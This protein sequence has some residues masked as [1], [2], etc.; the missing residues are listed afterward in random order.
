MLARIDD[1][2]LNKAQKTCDKFQRL[3]GLTKFRLEKWATIIAV[4]SYW[5]FAIEVRVLFLTLYSCIL[6]AMYFF[7]VRD[8]EAQEKAFLARN[9]LRDNI[10]Y[11]GGRIVSLVLY[12]ITLPLTLSLALASSAPELLWFCGWMASVLSKTYFSACIPRPPSKSK[13]R[14]WLEKGLTALRDSLPPE[15]I[16]VSNR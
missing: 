5:M 1:F 11:S 14:E 8:L 6:S 4:M 7:V 12:G 15:P 10:D 3:T 13:M 2:L 9:E 16:P